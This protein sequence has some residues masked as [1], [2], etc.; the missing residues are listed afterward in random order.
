MSEHITTAEDIRRLLREGEGPHVEFKRQFTNDQS[1]ARNIVAF[2]NSGGGTLIIGASDDGSVLGLDRDELKRAYSGL[3]RIASSLLLAPLYATGTAEIDGKMIVYLEIRE[4]PESARPIRLATGDAVERYGSTTITV[5]ETRTKV[6]P[7][8]SMRVFVAMSF[9][10]EEEPALVDY[11]EA[12]QRAA[13]ATKLPIELVRIDLVEGDYEISQRIM[14]EID[15]SDVVLADFT[16][17]PANVYFELGY[18]RGVKR[19]IIQ[20]ARKGTALE[21]DTRNWRTIFYKNA[22]ELQKAL[23]PALQ[24]AYAEVITRRD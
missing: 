14:D 9:R 23:V 24:D 21:F 8:R 3:K 11:F 19:R 17:G 20:T 12:M 7:S 18:A 1:L 13:V 22:T 2:A 16:L 10:N 15:R 5:T 6:A 4:A